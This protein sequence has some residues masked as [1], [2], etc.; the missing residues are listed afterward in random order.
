MN[1]SDFLH[2]MVLP[3]GAAWDE[4]RRREEVEAQLAV[5]QGELECLFVQNQQ[6]R[7]DMSGSK[8]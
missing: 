3:S 1:K 4:R 8:S 7:E 2:C 5:A 6:L